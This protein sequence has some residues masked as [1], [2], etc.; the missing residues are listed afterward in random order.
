[1]LKVNEGKKLRKSKKKVK[2][3]N[4]FGKSQKKVEKVLLGAKMLNIYKMLKKSMKF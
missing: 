2:V 4:K 1:M 3:G